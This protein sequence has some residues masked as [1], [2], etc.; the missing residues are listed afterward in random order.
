MGA[1]V[2]ALIGFGI[3]FFAARTGMRTRK[4]EVRQAVVR[5]GDSVA[6]GLETVIDRGPGWLEQLRARRPM[7]NRPEA[8]LLEDERIVDEVRQEWTR[9]GLRAPLI[10]ATVV[11]GTLYLRGRAAAATVDAMA[12]SARGL[13]PVRDLV[14]EAQR[15]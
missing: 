13:P 4:R 2:R 9:L 6:E 11:D 10:D 8:G 12:A 15:E 3:G 5:M 1:L 7:S 14:D